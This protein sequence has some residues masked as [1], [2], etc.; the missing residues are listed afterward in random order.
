MADRVDRPVEPGALPIPDARDPGV[1]S[2]CELAEQLGAADR[3]GRELL[4]DPRPHD[5]TGGIEVRGGPRELA[6]EPGQRRAL[7]AAH[8]EARIEAGGGVP[9]P[10]L[11]GAAHQR[12]D[13]RQQSDV[14]TF[15]VGVIEPHLRA[16]QRERVG[17]DVR[18]GTVHGGSLTRVACR[19]E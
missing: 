8:E 1:A 17:R 5:D 11:Q 10:L 2:P 3:G 16:D 19:C 9:A 7:V 14:R 4:V 12:L 15:A 18:R 6:V 13:A